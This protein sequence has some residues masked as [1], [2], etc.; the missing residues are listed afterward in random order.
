M[1]TA[2][3]VDYFHFSLTAK[4]DVGVRIRRLDLNAD[5]YIEDNDG[6]VIASSEETG[7][8]KEVVNVTLAANDAG[9]HYYVRV[10]G[11]EDGTNDYQFRY[12]A[13][14]PPNVSPSGLPTI[15]GAVAVGKTLLS[16]TSGI[17]DDNGLSG[18]TF[19]YQ[20]VKNTGGADAD[21]A[22]ETGS[23]YT[24]TASDTGAAF[25]VTVAFTDDA[26]YSESLTSSPTGTVPQEADDRQA[27]A[28][29]PRADVTLVSNRSLTGTVNLTEAEFRTTYQ[30][31]GFT[32]GSHTLGYNLTQVQ[33]YLQFASGHTLANLT[34]AIWEDD[35]GDPDRDSVVATLNNPTTAPSTT[36]LELVT[37]TAPPG[38]VLDPNTTYHIAFENSASSGTMTTGTVED[39]R[40]ES[41]KLAGW[42]IAD[43]RLSRLKNFGNSWTTSSQ[44]I[45]IRL[46]GSEASS[47]TS[48]DATLSGLALENPDD[49]S[50]IALDP[51]F[52]TATESYTAAVVNAVD[53]ISIIPT[54]NES[55]ATV[56][57]LDADDTALTDADTAEDDFQVDLDVGANT[58]KVKVTAEDDSTIKTYT[59]V[60]TRA[61]STPASTALVSNTGQTRSGEVDVGP[62]LNASPRAQK[63]TTGD[64]SGGYTI[65]E[66]VATLR[67]VGASAAPGVHIY[68]VLTSGK[69]GV[70]L[71]EFTNP[72]T[73]AA[74]SDNIFTAPANT[75][76]ESETDYFLVFIQPSNT[77]G[78]AHKYEIATTEAD[79]EDAGA[80]SGWSITDDEHYTKSTPSSPWATASKVLQI[81]I[82]GVAADDAT[83]VT[84][85]SNTSETHDS[86]GSLNAYDHAQKFTTGASSAGYTL[87]SV[88][89]VILGTT[90]NV[91]NITGSIN[92]INADDEP[93]TSLGTL[94]APTN[95]GDI[96]TYTNSSG[97]DLAASTP[98][99]V[100][101]D[102][103][104][105]G[106]GSV[107]NAASDAQTS[108]YGWT[109]A[110]GSVYRNKDN[111]GLWEDYANS[112][113]ILIIGT[114][115]GNTNV[116]A[117]GTPAITGAAQAGKT[118][119]ATVGTIADADGLP[120][121][122]PGDY[123]VQWV[124]VDADGSSNETEVSADSG[125][126]TLVAADVG[127]KIRVKVSFT[128]NGGTA[129]GPLTSDAYPS[130]ANVMAAKGTCPTGNDWCATL[131]LGEKASTTAV[132]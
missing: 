74:N 123:T 90:P 58:I 87:R 110:D 67:D 43:N 15:R 66:V 83:D 126:Y 119:T 80:A 45:R 101:I 102:S 70:S 112:K 47:T 32:T 127:K 121:T 99:F 111:T 120:T 35:S 92:E 105:N 37:L 68:S 33:A 22:G 31:Q 82:K 41:D 53:E 2:D 44:S 17:T 106:A 40:E 131:T 21:I 75:T 71:F 55:N 65:N 129:E 8:S 61:A 78:S 1:D 94:G 79:A 114:V 56:E 72:M 116:A 86:D 77:G 50:A 113:R 34:V 54:V 108:T 96:H 24:I 23:T 122:F 95:S 98:Y 29:T 3:T 62:S 52:A 124:R 51:A 11:K 103:E 84:L 38:T 49:S 76:L 63:F 36:A 42:S 91:A 18:A 89:V 28:I 85:V 115:K 132:S 93:G 16:D 30:T 69:P 97:I 20:W 107:S 25:K 117:T 104:S 109:I 73:L 13:E 128:D 9:E 81:Q 19:T 130:Y 125:T 59:V 100:L 46:T 39:N 4:R 27:R 60:V 118:L 64:V 48:T 5:L 88:G 12:F 14:A 7:D 6:T 10:E 57:Y 26:G